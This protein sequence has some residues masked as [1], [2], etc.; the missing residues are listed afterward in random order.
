LNDGG[1]AG[2]T[3]GPDATYLTLSAAE[4]RIAPPAANA[5]AQVY[6][7]EA[8]GAISNLERR[9]GDLRFTL[10]VNGSGLGLLAMA[11][12]TSCSLFI[13]GKP[14]APVRPAG[15]RFVTVGQQ[16]SDQRMI[17]TT[18]YEF[19]SPSSLQTT[20]YLARVRCAA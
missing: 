9:P 7:A 5:A 2:F 11:A 17:N 14:V 16:P 6:V 1:I 15:G 8:N 18:H 10:T 20:R 13:D 12:P 3:P 19:G 4:T